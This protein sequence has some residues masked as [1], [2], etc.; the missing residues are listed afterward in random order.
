MHVPQRL[1]EV[2]RELSGPGALT[3]R[4]TSEIADEIERIADWLEKSGISEIPVGG[5]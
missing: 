1:R 5:Q 3:Y 2:A 4:R